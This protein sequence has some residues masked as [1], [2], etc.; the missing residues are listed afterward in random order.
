[1]ADKEE[2]EIIRKKTELLEWELPAVEEE[3]Y[4]HKHVTEWFD[5]YVEIDQALYEIIENAGLIVT[6]Y[7]TAQ[8]SGSQ[9]S[10]T[11]LLVISATAG[12]KITLTGS[13]LDVSEG[14]CLYIVCDRPIKTAS[15]QLRAGT[16]KEARKKGNI[17]L[18]VVLGGKVYFRRTLLDEFT[19]LFSTVKELAGLIVVCTGLTDTPTPSRILTWTSIKVI[20]PNSGGIV[21]VSGSPLAVATGDHLYIAAALPLQTATKTLLKGTAGDMLLPGNIPL[22]YVASADTYFRPNVV[23]V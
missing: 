13:P 6:G 16:A 22:G 8:Y 1:M 2:I 15:V 5:F 11:E 17:A 23:A 21:T 19:P 7:D 18:G 14:Q 20:S 3:E 12:T 10:W 9:F 4:D